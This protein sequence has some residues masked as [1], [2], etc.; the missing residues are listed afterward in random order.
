M[1]VPTEADYLK[2]W[3]LFFLYTT[4][5]GFA[6]GAIAG[7]V[8]GA[9]CGALGFSAQVPVFSGAIGF[10]A[11]AGVSFAFF[12]YFVRRLVIRSAAPGVSSSVPDVA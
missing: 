6:A 4:I 11:G 8:V 7:A 9:L 2:S 1:K 12:R 3:A 5:G 10:V